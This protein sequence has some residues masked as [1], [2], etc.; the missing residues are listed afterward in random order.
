M[1][2]MQHTAKRTDKGTSIN[3][4]QLLALLERWSARGAGNRCGIPAEAYIDHA[5]DDQISIFLES[6]P[7]Q[8]RA[9][10]LPGTKLAHLSMKLLSI[11]SCVPRIDIPFTS[12]QSLGWT[13]FESSQYLQPLIDGRSPTMTEVF[14]RI[15]YEE[16]SSVP[17]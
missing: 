3:P 17:L 16:P 1:F 14:Y 11:G 15:D 5:V 6:L 8:H 4:S 9:I 10:L 12:E 13:G 7:Q 2:N